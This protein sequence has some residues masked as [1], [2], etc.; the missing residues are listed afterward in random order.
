MHSFKRRLLI[1]L[2]VFTA[3]GGTSAQSRRVVPNPTPTPRDEIERVNTEEIKLNV[4]AFDENGAFFPD[5]TANDIV[6]TDN[7]VLHPP[8]SVRRIPANV[9]VVMD[10]GGELRAVKSLE[11]TR[12]VAK[13]VVSSLRSG[14]S[15]ALLQYSDQADIVQEWT[16][17]KQQMLSAIS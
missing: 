12:R 3:I 10:T 6:I 2:F 14:D 15:M 7:D 5:V 9:L 17:D 13:A 4:L 1:V 16:N 11:Q 8:S